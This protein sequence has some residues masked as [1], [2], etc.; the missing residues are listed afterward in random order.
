MISGN[1]R[2]LL[3]LVVALAVTTTGCASTGMH[4]AP[5]PSK[6]DT[7]PTAAVR[8]GAADTAPA[9]ADPRLSRLNSWIMSR[10]TPKNA[11]ADDLPLGTGDLIVVSVFLVSE[12]SQLNVRIPSNGKIALPLVGILPAAGRT[13]RQL[14]E[15][16]GVRLERYMHE[17]QVSVFVQEHKS[18]QVAVFGAVRNGGV[19]PLLSRLRVT[20]AL[21]M[22]GA[23]NEDADHVV[24]LIRRPSPRPDAASA[25]P[26][27]D[28]ASVAP[29][30]DAASAAPRPADDEVMIPIDLESVIND[31]KDLNLVLESGD[32][33]HVPRAGAYYVGGDVMKP[34]SFLLKGKTT[35]HQAV[36]IAGGVKQTAD[37][38]DVRIYRPGSD[39]QPEVLKF[40]LNEVENRHG[41][42][43][44]ELAKNDVVIVGRSGAKALGYGLLEFI[45]FGVGMSIP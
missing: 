1:L 24:Y 39:G 29:Q 5:A 9:Q 38:N 40:S 42:Q 45:R 21:A 41:A 8:P 15:D 14:E 7:A 16:I 10:G 11:P 2:R 37:R 4:A 26:Q 35:L 25:A 22:A 18:Q 27:L 19:Y 44:V 28:A 36:V 33:I 12:L 31:R 17:P 3:A 43:A 13:A 30:P 32:V 34:G 23:L 6:P 20:D